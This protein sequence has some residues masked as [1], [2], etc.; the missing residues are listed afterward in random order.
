MSSSDD[1]ISKVNTVRHRSP[2]GDKQKSIIAI[3]PNYFIQTD[4][5]YRQFPE[6]FF[7]VTFGQ[8][9]QLLPEQSPVVSSVHSLTV[10]FRTVS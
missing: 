6:K 9:L 3:F 4:F 2:A 7:I 1:L 8:H 10:T 5:Y